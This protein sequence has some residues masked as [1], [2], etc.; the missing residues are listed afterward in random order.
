MWTYLELIYCYIMILKFFQIQKFVG[1]FLSFILLSISVLIWSIR[2]TLFSIS[3]LVN[4]SCK[5]F[6]L[7]IKFFD[8]H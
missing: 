2:K 1:R 5:I 8:V 7:K 6:H 4:I 3:Q